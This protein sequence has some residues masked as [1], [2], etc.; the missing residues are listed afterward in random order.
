MYYGF[1]FFLSFSSLRLD[2]YSESPLKKETI[3]QIKHSGNNIIDTGS[4][5]TGINLPSV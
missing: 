2:L 5:N 3:K 4:I 1:V